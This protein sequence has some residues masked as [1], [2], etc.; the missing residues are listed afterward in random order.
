MNHPDDL[1]YS[2]DHE[3]ARL[4][5]GKTH[6]LADAGATG[7]EQ[8]LVSAPPDRTSPGHSCGEYP[9]E[10]GSRQPEE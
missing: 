7:T 4:D 3:W 5:G 9:R 1:R 8:G 6:D 2:A 10:D